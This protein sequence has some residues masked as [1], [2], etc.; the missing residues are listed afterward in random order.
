MLQNYG[1]FY[2]IAL[3]ILHLSKEIKKKKKKSQYLHNWP[4][5]LQNI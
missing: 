2:E 3:K 5:S 1:I 4:L